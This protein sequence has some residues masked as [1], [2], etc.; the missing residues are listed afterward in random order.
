MGYAQFTLRCT[1]PLHPLAE[2][3]G[4]VVE[5]AADRAELVVPLAIVAG[6]EIAGGQGVGDFGEL[7]RRG[8]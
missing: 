3:A 7:T 2:L 4:H 5:R 6:A 1:E 8:Q